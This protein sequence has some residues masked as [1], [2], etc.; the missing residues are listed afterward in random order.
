MTPLALSFNG[1]N[2][3]IA[4]SVVRQFV[5]QTVQHCLR[6]FF[7][8]PVLALG[9]EVISL[10]RKTIS[11]SWVSQRTINLSKKIIFIPEYPE[12]VPLQQFVPSTRTC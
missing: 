7:I 6:S 3:N 1:T 9:S 8:H 12:D 10:L 4:E 11:I 5:H 2:P